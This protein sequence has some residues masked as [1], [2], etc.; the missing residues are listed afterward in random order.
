MT[1]TIIDVPVGIYKV[2][3][4]LPWSL[5]DEVT[6]AVLLKKKLEYKNSYLSGNVHPNVYECIWWMCLCHMNVYGE[7]T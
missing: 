1:G 7:C 4:T 5:D 3:T 6:I 2:K